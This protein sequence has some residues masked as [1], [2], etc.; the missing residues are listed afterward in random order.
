VVV[1]GDE[2]E[3]GV[4]HLL[5]ACVLKRRARPR[6]GSSSRC[7]RCFPPRCRPRARRRRAPGG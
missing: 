6:R 3:G 7:G 4:G 2:G 1:D 5:G